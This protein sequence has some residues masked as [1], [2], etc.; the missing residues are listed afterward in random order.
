MEE[1]RIK[2]GGSSKMAA[3][4]LGFGYTNGKRGSLEFGFPSVTG[5][6]RKLLDFDLSE[7]AALDYMQDLKRDLFVGD[8]AL[9]Q[10]STVNFSLKEQKAQQSQI[11]SIL[12][13]A[14][15]IMSNGP[16]SEELN[17]VS[18][19][20]V[21]FYFEQKE[22]MTD[23]LKGIHSLELQLGDHE[24]DKRVIINQVKVV[25]QPLGSAMDFLLH[26]DGSMRADC[27]KWAAGSIGVL[28]VGFFTND[29]LVLNKMEVLRDHSRSL[30]SGMSVAYK[31]MSDAG[32][33]LPIYQLDK[34]IREGSFAAAKEKAF[35][36]LAGQ[37]L[38]EIETY[39][40]NQL[41]LILVTGGGGADL[42]PY[43]Q[44]QI[45]DAVLLGQMSNVRGY[46]KIGRR[47]W[48]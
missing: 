29:L 32:I 14:L 26:E 24:I 41:D 10:S 37:I 46:H 18:G 8:L 44:H 1:I 36:A 30:R 28:D 9:R 42:F 20:P 45:P 43:I 38:G 2:V 22:Q 19:L 16:F 21:T 5:P 27:K 35:S 48:R 33:D 13:T 11:S 25:P 40:G 31:A 7:K 23:L 12:E 47:S 39:W 3:L 15:G 6:A 34:K 17:L 4:D